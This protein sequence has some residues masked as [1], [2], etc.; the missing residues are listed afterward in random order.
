VT[1]GRFAGW[2]PEDEVRRAASLGDLHPV[3]PAAR[4]RVESTL[5]EA[6]EVILT[7]Q[8]PTAVVEDADGTFRGTVRL[9]AIR[10]GLNR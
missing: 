6:L 4:V 3:P 9:E 7:Q 5:R 8:T 2:V 10:Q 1:E